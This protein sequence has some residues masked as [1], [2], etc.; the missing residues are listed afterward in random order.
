MSS[1]R[2]VEGRKPRKKREWEESEIVRIYKP[3]INSDLFRVSGNLHTFLWNVKKLNWNSKPYSMANRQQSAFGSEFRISWIISALWGGLGRRKSPA[4]GRKNSPTSNRS[5]IMI[6][7][8]QRPK[9]LGFRVC[10]WLICCVTLKKTL[11]FSG[12]QFLLS[13]DD[14]YGAFKSHKNFFFN[15]FFF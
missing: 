15:F 6:E 14:S 11:A 7:E 12:L 3:W 1:R 10:I 13:A 4:K 9:N 5:R 2:R 8:D